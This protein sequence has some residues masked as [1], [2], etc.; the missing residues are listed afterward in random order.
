MSTSWQRKNLSAT[1]VRFFQ[2]ELFPLP[3]YCCMCSYIQKLYIFHTKTCWNTFKVEHQTLR[4]SVADCYRRLEAPIRKKSITLDT[5]HTTGMKATAMHC[6]GVRLD[7]VLSDSTVWFYW[8]TIK[9][10]ERWKKG[11]FV[12]LIKKQ[13]VKN[14]NNDGGRWQVCH[15]REQFLY[16]W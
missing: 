7:V 13:K 5:F 14:V 10:G 9:Q 6:L 3:V 8:C 4:V 15:I 16:V 2:N 11:A 12:M 1:S